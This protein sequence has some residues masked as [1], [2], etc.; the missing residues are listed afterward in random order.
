MGYNGTPYW[1]QRE[2]EAI[3][4]MYHNSELSRQLSKEQEL[5]KEIEQLKK[6]IKE[7][8]AENS[9]LRKYVDSLG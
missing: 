7:L 8:E 1:V 3:S 2:R 4:S 9:D 5:T 6:R